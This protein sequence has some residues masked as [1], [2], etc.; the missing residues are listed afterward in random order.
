[1]ICF[2]NAK[3]NIGLNVVEKR[4][5]G[6]HNLETIFFPFGMKDALECI[7][8][9][10]LQFVNSGL[11]IDGN[12]HN[13]LC[14]KA[15]KL[16]KQDFD[17]PPVHMHLH[18]AIPFGAG[19][20][21]G[22]SDATCTIKL[23]NDYFKLDISKEKMIEYALVLGS[24]CPIFVINRSCYGTGRG[25]ILESITL[26]LNGYFL[27]LINPGIHIPTS[28]A[29]ASI[30]PHQ[31]KYDLRESIQKPIS[32]WNKYIYN[33]FENSIFPKYPNIA[34]IKE[35]LYKEGALFVAMSGSGSS[36]FGIFE[37]KV[38]LQEIFPH[39]YCWIGLL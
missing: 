24:D 15:W 12:P 31:P 9:D 28:E 8:S 37:Q 16:L 6:F 22:S 7:E 34:G 13:N 14:I 32:E 18:K 35:T 30:T 19:L 11:I 5:D 26:N 2:P 21:G 39:Y 20:G 33:D 4:S 29:F 17:I 1:M 36:V 10:S 25:E 38:A 27:G 3:I 23:L